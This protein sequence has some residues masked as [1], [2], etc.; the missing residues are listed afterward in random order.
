MKHDAV[1]RLLMTPVTNNPDIVLPW[2]TLA[3]ETF[4]DCRIFSIEKVRRRSSA[5]GREGDFFTIVSN[6]WVNVVAI[7]PGNELVLIRQYRQGSNE[8][9]LEIPGG[10]VDEGEDPID[11]ARRELLE[12]TGYSCAS[13]MLIGR[14]RPNPAI[15]NNWAYTVLA[16][17]LSEPSGQE[18]DE[19]EEIDVCTLPVEHVE[20]MLREGVITHSLVVNALL[21]YKL[22]GISSGQALGATTGTIDG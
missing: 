12:E 11:A 22:N 16:T 2:E 10:I 6:D 18:L 9:T 3:R 20:S 8:I 5:S 14:V 1:V 17:G 4:A 7:T 19:H 15:M 21:W 13:A